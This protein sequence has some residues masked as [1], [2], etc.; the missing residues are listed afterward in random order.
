MNAADSITHVGTCSHCGTVAPISADATAAYGEPT[1]STCWDTPE[2][3]QSCGNVH[4]Y[5]DPACPPCST[6]STIHDA[7]EACADHD[8]ATLGGASH[9]IQEPYPITGSGRWIEDA[10]PDGWDEYAQAECIAAERG[11]ATYFFGSDER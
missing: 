1:C 11:A 7:D 6:C 10:D 9:L 5:S 2:Y 3:C 8:A 4:P